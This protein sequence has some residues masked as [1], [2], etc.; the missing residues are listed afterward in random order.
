MVEVVVDET[1]SCY[2]EILQVV[3]VV[4]VTWQTTSEGKGR[5]YLKMSL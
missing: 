2:Y 4:V 1:A 3:V 5:S